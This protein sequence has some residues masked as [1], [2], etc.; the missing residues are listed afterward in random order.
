MAPGLRVPIS[1]GQA[2][3]LR[4]RQGI[5]KRAVESEFSYQVVDLPYDPVHGL[6]LDFKDCEP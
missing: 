2:A 6:S 1:I 3:R 5:V 4:K